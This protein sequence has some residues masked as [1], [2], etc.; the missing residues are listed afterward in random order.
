MEGFR[1]KDAL[2]VEKI[3]SKFKVPRWKQTWHSLRMARSVEL[4]RVIQGNVVGRNKT[5]CDL[6]AIEATNIFS[7]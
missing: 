1:Y 4:D 7:I 5:M 2:Q 6:K 3:K